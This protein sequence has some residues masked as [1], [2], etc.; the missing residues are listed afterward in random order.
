MS[1]PSLPPLI[2]AAVLWTVSLSTM[3]GNDGVNWACADS[4][5]YRSNL[6]DPLN[7]YAR[8]KYLMATQ[9]LKRY[10]MLHAA[11]DS[12]GNDFGSSK[13]HALSQDA[14]VTKVRAY[15]S[16]P[17]AFTVEKPFDKYHYAWGRCESNDLPSAIAFIDAVYHAIG[18][19]ASADA[20]IMAR[21]RLLQLCQVENEQAQIALINE[22]EASLLS[23]GGDARAADWLTYLGAAAAFYQESSGGEEGDISPR[24][25]T[26]LRESNFDWVSDTADYMAV[27]MAKE[28]LDYGDV[29]AVED[30]EIARDA[31]LL[32]HQ[33]G[34]YVSTVRD[35][36]LYLARY[37]PDEEKAFE[38]MAAR[39]DEVL[40]KE[41][42]LPADQ[43][44]S[45]L[46][47]L[48]VGSDVGLAMKTPPPKALS[49]VDLH[50]LLLT[51]ILLTEVGSYNAPLEVNWSE[52][53]QRA[54]GRMGA[55][56]GLEPYTELLLHA[57][58]GDYTKIAAGTYDEATYGPL[59]AD[60]ILLQARAYERLDQ[61]SL[62]IQSWTRLLT[63]TPTFNALTEIANQ[64]VAADRF[65]DFAYLPLSLVSAFDDGPADGDFFC[66]T[67]FSGGVDA[68]LQ[69]E[70]P[71]RH[72]LHEGF[73]HFVAPTD[74]LVVSGDSKLHPLARY[75]ASEPIMRKQ[76]MYADYEGFLKMSSFLTS[77]SFLDGLTERY[78]D[79]HEAS[80]M[81][82]GYTEAISLVERL[83]DDP[84]DAD[85][86]TRLGYF[87]YSKQLWFN[88][89]Y[90][91]TLWARTLSAY[92]CKN[93]PATSKKPLAPIE[94]FSQALSHY[95]EQPM[96]TAE[97][98]SLL[99]IMIYCFKGRTNAS[100]CTF[101]DTENYPES[102]RKG[103][104]DRLI[105]EFPTSEHAEYWY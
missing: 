85:A 88:C 43:R 29:T 80:E 86:L 27:R 79:G 95:K 53:T 9:V 67:E 60:A 25:F 98:A 40:G 102:A 61:Q 46:R 10:G 89:D 15:L 82:A 73:A 71:F 42:S 58:A 101:G 34:R 66:R 11:I 68:F 93:L 49:S 19:G 28:K 39:F 35:L 45:V 105:K 64:L 24:L 7:P 75:Y 21:H 52:T 26:S 84:E 2:V 83:L 59:L 62:A 81:V 3:A 32:N 92:G 37:H 6:I 70:D 99:R 94:M 38:M 50:P 16:T 74:A 54:R 4:I 17:D 69:R 12:V 8:P 57:I 63:T 18:K 14:Y 97:E 23:L 87:R 56:H 13:D 31:Y 33:N 5:G 22:I 96:R 78:P 103:Y 91:E 55:Y 77:E 1:R 44:E 90:R 41:S 47:D 65:A 36:G 48:M 30:L 76:L 51:S 20:L 100:N 104:F 72:L